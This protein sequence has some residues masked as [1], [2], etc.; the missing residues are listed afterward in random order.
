MGTHLWSLKSNL[1]TRKK[2][3]STCRA[4]ETVTI[5]APTDKVIAT[6]TMEAIDTGIRTPARMEPEKALTTKTATLHSLET[7]VVLFTEMRILPEVNGL[8]NNLSLV[9]KYV[10]SARSNPCYQ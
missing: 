8:K 1:Q 6:P 7:K 3:N 2:K 10:C 5:L 4:K 9:C